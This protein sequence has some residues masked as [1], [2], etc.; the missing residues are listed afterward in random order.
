MY[1]CRGQNNQE[2]I[3][4]F[5]YSL[6]YFIKEGSGSAR[7]QQVLRDIEANFVVL[8]TGDLLVSC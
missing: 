8:E 1:L 6:K 4:H 7:L 3:V 5:F 2:G